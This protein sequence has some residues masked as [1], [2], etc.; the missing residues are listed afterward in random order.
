MSTAA[1]LSPQPSVA[2][3]ETSTSA[4]LPPPQLPAVP[5]P[6]PAIIAASVAPPSSSKPAMAV[7]TVS[8]APGAAAE[9][10]VESAVSSPR[11]VS[12]PWPIV[13]EAP[14]SAALKGAD[15]LAYAL[16]YQVEEETGGERR[17]ESSL[18]SRH[19]I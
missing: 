10:P 12:P 19:L 13:P 15:A 8:A 5:P 11:V 7:A 1:P 6:P 3:V 14:V 18:H 17:S 2:S 9:T 16:A 4:P